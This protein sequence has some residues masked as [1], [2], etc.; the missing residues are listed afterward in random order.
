MTML[1]RKVQGSARG[2]AQPLSV[3]REIKEAYLRYYDTAFWLR[4][5]SLRQERRELLERSGSILT[6]PFIE[7]MLP[8]DPAESIAD[9]CKEVGLSREVADALGRML[10]DRDGAFRLRAHQARALRVSLGNGPTRNIV[11]TSGTGSG[12]TESFLLPIFGR[13]L[14]EARSWGGQP[15]IH[16]WWSSEEQE[17]AWEPAR[18]DETR[19]AA[20][21][22]IIL[23]PTNAL[24]EDQ[25]SRLRK[26]I[27]SAS[28][29]GADRSP[30]FWFGRYTGATLGSGETPA[31][32][33]DLSARDAAEQL[34]L[35]ETDHEKMGMD[36][37]ELTSQF[38]DPRNGELL[39]RWDMVATPP[40][41][42]VTNY[43]MLNVMLM[44]EREEPLFAKTA[45]WLNANPDHAL[46]L[47]VDELHTYRGTQGTEVALVVRNLLRRL[48]IRPGSD[49]LRCIGTSASI[50]QNSGQEYLEQFFSVDRSTFEITPGSPRA[51]QPRPP[52]SRSQFA[53]LHERSSKPGYVDE[54][55]VLAKEQ[56]VDRA[57]AAACLDGEVTRATR[58]SVVDE[59]LFDTPADGGLEALEAVLEAVTAQVE[60]EGIPFRAHLFTRSVRGI[61]ACSNPNCTGVAPSSGRTVGKLFAAPALTCDA[62]GSRVLELFY[63]DQCGEV[64]L[65]GFVAELPDDLG[66]RQWFLSSLPPASTASSQV[67]AFRRPYGKY[68]WYCPGPPPRD[69]TSWQHQAP[70]ARRATQFRFIGAELDHR[71]GLLSPS[72]HHGTG[73]MLAV[74]DAPEGSDSVPALPERCPRC[75]ARGVNRKPRLF[76]RGVVRS[77]IRGHATGTARLTQVLLDRITRAVGEAPADARTIVFTDSRDDAA[78]TAAGVELNHFRDLVRQ[79]VT[80]EVEAASP[81]AAV[82]RRG[83][84]APDLLTGEERR[85]LDYLQKHFPDVWAAF[86]LRARGAASEAD[87]RLI[88]D[89][90]QEHGGSS[91]RLAWRNLTMRISDK[92]VS[93]GV[94]PAGPAASRQ[95]IQHEH[96]WRYFAA[97]QE[98]EW[99]P[100]PLGERE[101]GEERILDF[102]QVHVAEALFDRGGRDYE[103]I[104]LGWLEPREWRISRMPLPEEKAREVVLSAIRILGLA[105]RFPGSRHVADEAMPLALR[106]Y[107]AKVASENGIE[108]RELEHALVEAL[109]ESRLLDG[110]VLRLPELHVARAPAG[111]NA[112]R[113]DQCAR[114]HLN[115]SAGVCTTSGCN[116]T[117][118]VRVDLGQEP[119]D[120]YEWLAGDVPRRLRIEELTGQ[121]KPLAEQR[122][123]QRR[124]KGALLK[125]PAESSLL[126]AIDVLSVT[127]TMEVGVDIGSLRS[128]M[129]ANMP[130][131]RFN[132]QQRVGRAGRKGQ[133]F[134]YGV[135]L[136]RD[137]SHDD[138]YFN[139]PHRITGDPPSQPYLDLDNEQI[140]R[141]VVAAE[142]L[143]QAYLALP[144]DMRP[145]WTRFSAHGTFGRT[146]EWESRFRTPVAEW[147]RTSPA[148][149]ATIADLVSHTGLKPETVDAIERWTRH[150]LVTA[151]DDA[152]R[153]TALTQVEMSERLANAAVLPMFG[154][155]TRVRPLY[156][157]SPT[158]LSDDQDAQVSDRSL[159]IAIAQFAP[160]AEVLRD[161]QLH[162]CVGFAA[163]EF[164]GSHPRPVDPLGPRL[165]IARC[166]SCGA[167]E[168]R[169]QHDTHPCRVCLATPRFFDLYQPLGFR[170]DYLPQ[171]FDD[172]AERGF[173]GSLPELGWEPD[174]GSSREFG[175]ITVQG[176][177]GATVFSINDNRGDLF[178]MYD[179]RRTV[180]VPRPDFYHDLPDLPLDS[181]DGIPRT[182]AAIGSVRQTDVLVL[183]LDRLHLPGPQPT[184]TVD[185]GRMPAGLPALWSFAEVFRRASALELE[186]DARELDIGLQ[187]FQIGDDIGRRVFIAD[188]SDNGAGYS[189][190]IADP[191]V[192]DRVFNRIV[193]DLASQFE[194]PKHSKVC[195]SSCPDCLQSYDNHLLHHH[196]D[197]RLGL[198]LAEVA[199]GRPLSVSRW[200]PL[201]H[202]AVVTFAGG[203][204]LTPI[205][206]GNLWGAKEERS[207]RVAFFGHPLWRLDTAYWVEDQVIASELASLNHGASHVRAFDLY[208]LLHFPQEVAK[209]LVHG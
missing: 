105:Q 162:V 123:R 116:H 53:S 33:S 129:M 153:S 136:C 47:V 32:T 196:L 201:A 48:G 164:R 44:R 186:L 202:P 21:R 68:M 149:A 192:L 130:P 117:G 176:R 92:M 135:T 108:L 160:G 148:V 134:S 124:F 37:L 4:D 169:Q 22:A 82:M 126:H 7:P 76:F 179:Y 90:E 102:L 155:P 43:S 3:H 120:Y 84:D 36:D 157:R 193:N 89:F 31:R 175:A 138:F 166:N 13:L 67:P 177:S 51:V 81:P 165:T 188:A 96:W 24:V 11:V 174:S 95:T 86:R 72:G 52:L 57:L 41:I 151:I 184:V 101:R 29:V 197:W 113:C 127:T 159:D 167:V 144:A 133:P 190:R 20:I 131:Q 2:L 168:P 8:Y 180:V 208:T 185:G 70:G 103:S 147:L 40:D 10:F 137:R 93:L 23:Y 125:A 78:A 206:L 61:W 87:S 15:P 18:R 19:P 140:V 26:A 88:A 109:R 49:Q 39:T 73:T 6:E 118:L 187:P 122:A 146:T 35:M 97:P 107:L 191:D 163:W 178:P 142:L 110:W 55:R 42:L 132:Y 28:A 58:L 141:R 65:G 154:F 161:K 25:I 209:W 77:P 158:G 128:V 150:G 100:L 63:C 207:G 172:Q 152:V 139:N 71:I 38:P 34:R 189:T 112:W 203:F 17:E 62:C 45:A 114:I 54:L 198:D 91:G 27:M 5:P 181:F 200:L 170:T 143:R 14:A 85:E 83:V 111:Q 204:A 194:G 205:S 66:D 69:V 64:S 1:E 199:A 50:D 80:A 173:L 106:R 94:N 9:V 74:S 156:Y 30:R 195:D 145:V 171:D 16:R 60:G 115:P 119:Q 59:H 104:G 121:T 56:E 46:T 182:I 79:L 99:E 12:K 75:D 98:G 183:T